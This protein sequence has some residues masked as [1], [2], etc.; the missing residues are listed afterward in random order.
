M[1]FKGDIGNGLVMPSGNQTKVPQNENWIGILKAKG[2]E[3]DHLELGGE[4]WKILIK[5]CKDRDRSEE[6][7]PVYGTMERIC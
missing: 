2:Q 6:T 1:K 4:S 5:K 3:E 7:V